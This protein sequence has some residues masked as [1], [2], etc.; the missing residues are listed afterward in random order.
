MNRRK[1]AA[2]LLAVGNDDFEHTCPVG[3][4]DTDESPIDEPRIRRVRW[5]D[6]HEGFR[7][8][9]GQS[10]TLP[11]ACHR[12]P[13]VAYPTGVEPQW[14]VL[15]DIS[16]QCR[17][18]AGNE[19][20]FA[21]RREKLSVAKESRRRSHHSLACRP[22]HWIECGEFIIIKLRQ[23]ADIEITRTPVLE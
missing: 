2:A 4:T 14:K 18:C 20:R 21:V 5:M 6:F 23:R 17:L 15:G 16:T 8:M 19:T 11:G 1:Q 7:R 9:I 10:R 12:V 13:L 3:R 22:L